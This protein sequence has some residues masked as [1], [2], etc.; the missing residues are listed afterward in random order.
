MFQSIYTLI[1][2]LGT[3]PP[4]PPLVPVPTHFNQKEPYTWNAQPSGCNLLFTLT[5]S[6]EETDMLTEW[7]LGWGPRGQVTLAWY[8]PWA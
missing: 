8:L 1:E 2:T 7:P 3:A 5:T 6:P 4:K